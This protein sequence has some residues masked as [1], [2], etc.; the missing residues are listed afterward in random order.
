MMMR[1]APSQRRSASRVAVVVSKKICKSAVGRNR[2]RRRIFE[3]VRHE[4]QRI[5][6]PHDI[7]I[8]VSSPE[9]LAMTPA[10][11]YREIMSLL[12]PITSPRSQP[13]TD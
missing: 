12:E 11:L 8:T 9:V 1:Y 5:S 2:A 3:I 7:V 13:T 10:D 6:S 4:Y